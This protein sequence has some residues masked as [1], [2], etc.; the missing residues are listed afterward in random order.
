[1]TRISAYSNTGKSKLTYFIGRKYL[2]RGM[3]VTYVSLEVPKSVIMMNLIANRMGVN[4]WDIEDGKVRPDSDAMDFRGLTI[5]DDMHDWDAI[6][7]FVEKNAPDL[8]VID[9]V[10]NI[11]VKGMTELYP[12]MEFLASEIQLLAIRTGTRILDVSQVA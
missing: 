11:R 8:L 6:C 12:K 3:K 7:E 1:M 4:V 9:Y 5:V 10:Q 2:D